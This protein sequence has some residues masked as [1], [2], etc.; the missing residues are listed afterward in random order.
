MVSGDED[1]VWGRGR[2]IRLWGLGRPIRGA[3]DMPF[4]GRGAAD[5]PMGQGYTNPPIRLKA[6]TMKSKS[7]TKIMRLPM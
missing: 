1:G 3:A 2:P 6:S 7:F 5:T 4:F